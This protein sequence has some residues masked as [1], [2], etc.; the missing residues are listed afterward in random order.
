VLTQLSPKGS[1]AVDGVSLT[2]DAGPFARSFTI[3]LIPETLRVTRFASIRVNDLVNLEV[4]VLAKAGR[5]AAGRDA[6][7][8]GPRQQHGHAPLT[9]QDVLS[10]GWQ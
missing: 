5:L 7:G 2:L 1:I 9:L 4:D 6:P 10:R 3:T 8:N